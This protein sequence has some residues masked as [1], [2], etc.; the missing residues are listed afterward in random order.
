MHTP[1]TSRQQP[2]SAQ[3]P[4]IFRSPST[5]TPQK[6]LYNASSQAG[7]VVPAQRGAGPITNTVMSQLSPIERARKTINETLLQE[8]RFLELDLYITRKLPL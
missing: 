3:R 5:V 7:P 4:H 6:Q 2:A 1:A 8:A